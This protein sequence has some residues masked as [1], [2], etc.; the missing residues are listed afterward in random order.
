[1]VTVAAQTRAGRHSLHKNTCHFGSPGIKAFCDG[2]WNSR[3]V[4]IDVVCELF[5]DPFRVEMGAAGSSC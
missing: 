3:D 4:G 2:T 1:M 5:S